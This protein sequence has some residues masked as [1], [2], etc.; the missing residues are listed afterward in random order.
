MVAI[1]IGE[2]DFEQIK[3][4]IGQYAWE[5]CDLNFPPGY[6]I[7]S[8]LLKTEP[9][10]E[11]KIQ[12]LIDVPN[13]PIFYGDLLLDWPAYCESITCLCRCREDGSAIKGVSV[14]PPYWYESY[15]FEFKR[16]FRYHEPNDSEQYWRVISRKT[17]MD[18]L[19]RYCGEQSGFFTWQSQIQ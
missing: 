18:W 5:N 8:R 19:L 15:S 1:L 7:P 6:W 14:L 4:L 13:L 17:D 2:T 3:S 10:Y 11:A 16:C 12:P 9:A